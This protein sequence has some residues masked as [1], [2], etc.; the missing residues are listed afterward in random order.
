MF[1]FHVPIVNILHLTICVGAYL[2]NYVSI[3]AT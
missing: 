2:L 1:F 3:L